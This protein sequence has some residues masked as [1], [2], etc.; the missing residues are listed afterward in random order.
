MSF[1]RLTPDDFV[2]SSDAISAV[3]WTTGSPAL[4]SFY[5]SSAQ[6]A[7]SSGNYYLNVYDTTT[8]ASIQ[9]AIAY[10]NANGSGSAN[11]DNQVNGKSPTSTVFGQWQDLVIGDENTNFAIVT[12]KQIGRAHV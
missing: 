10:G 11:Y 5:T 1:V 3:C 8:T 4:T 7:G 2:V 9:F 6:S 12:G